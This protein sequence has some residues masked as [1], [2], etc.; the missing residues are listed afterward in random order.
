MYDNVVGGSD[1]LVSGTGSADYMWG[2]AVYKDAAAVG[3]SDVFVFAPNNGQ[4]VMYD[5]EQGK[6]HI[7]L[8]AIKELDFAHLGISYLDGTYS[9]DN[10]SGQDAAV[11]GLRG[12]NTITAVGFDAS[13]PLTSNDFFF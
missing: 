2:D 13:H 4:D 8:T 5:L 3:G 6:D 12:G 10:V 9:D 1:R 7:D 11:I